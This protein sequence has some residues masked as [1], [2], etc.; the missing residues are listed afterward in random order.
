VTALR[1]SVLALVSSLAQAG[2]AVIAVYALV[3]I[4]GAS[5][6]AAGEAVDGIIAPLGS[7][8]LVGLGL[9]LLWRGARGLWVQGRQTRRQ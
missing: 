7:A 1:L 9:Y 6:Q 8:L 2:V 3:A 4:L 5:R